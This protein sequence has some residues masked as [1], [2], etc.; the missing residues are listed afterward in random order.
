L[1]NHSVLI[2]RDGR[3]YPI[4]DSGAPIIDNNGQILGIILVF[5]DQTAERKTQKEILEAREQLKER[6]RFLEHLIANLPGMIYRCKNDRDWTM[7]Y[8]AGAC[9]EITG[10][11]PEDLINNRKLAYND[12]IFPEHQEFVWKRW[13]EALDQKETFEDEYEIRTADGK[14]K[15]V[16]ERGSGVYDEEGH[17]I[18]LEGFITDISERKKAEQELVKSEGEKS[19]IFA[20]ISEHV[21]ELAPDL[22]VIWANRAAIESLGKK[23]NEVIG[24]KCYELVVRAQRA[25][26]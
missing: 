21:L 3:E 17:L 11:E 6:N 18:C 7:E 15:W 13:Q 2:S 1:A 23:E 22:T 5:R 14:I 26:P 8:I 16:W 10:Y 24:K 25:L 4:A 20:T 9:R 19:A 12:L